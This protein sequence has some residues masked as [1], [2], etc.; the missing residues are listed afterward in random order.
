MFNVE[1]WCVWADLENY[2][3]EGIVYC[4]M[5]DEE[6]YRGLDS[7]RAAILFAMYKIN[8][9]Q[10]K[11]ISRAEAMFGKE[12]AEQ[13]HLY[14]CDLR[15]GEAKRIDPEDLL[16]APELIKKDRLNR[17]YEIDWRKLDTSEYLPY[18]YAF[19]EAPHEGG[20]YDP[21]DFH[22]IN[23]ALFPNGTEPLEVYEWTTDWSD[24]FD[25]GH[26]WWGASCWSI[27]D[28]SLDR[29]VTILASAT[30]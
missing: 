3:P 26:E 29:F 30:D 6:P 20:R 28:W 4:I 2:D 16:Y 23:Q 10:L 13:L 12:F 22:K 8:D 21:D 19:L 15:R 27:Y 14:N 9:K 1:V 11:T 24:F 25:D 7:H 18:W 5:E 17:D